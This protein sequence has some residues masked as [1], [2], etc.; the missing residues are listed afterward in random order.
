MKVNKWTLGLAAIGLVSLPTAMLAEEELSPVQTAL[1]STIISGYVNAAAQWDF[2][3]GNQNAPGYSYNQ[4]KQDG[5]S[6]NSVL[7][8][9]EK[10]YE[11]DAPG[12]WA[13]G[14]KID[15]MF[16]PDADAFGTTMNTFGFSGTTD[17]APPG[18]HTHDY[19]N[20][21]SDTDNFALRQ[22]HLN[23]RAPVGRGLDFKV[24]VFDTI[25]GYESHDAHKNP[26]YTRSYGYTIEPLSHTGVLASYEFIEDTL[27]ASAGIANTVGPAINSRAYYT[28][29]ESFKTY[30]GSLAFT[31]PESM[32]FLKGST[33]Y[34]GIVNGFAGGTD[35][36]THYYAGGTLMTPVEDLRAGVAFDYVDLHSPAG[37]TDYHWAIG[38]YLTYKATDKLSLH[39]RGEYAA[40]SGDALLGASKLVGATATVQY[41]LWRNVMSRLE[42]RW[43]HAADGDYAF[44]GGS[45]GRNPGVRRN[46]YMAA[47]N[48]IYQF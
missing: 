1:A 17:P 20:G 2:G 27:V 47:L 32:G 23:L 13:A 4:N 48:T 24:G 33:L 36:L 41:D 45:P 11:A 35:N 8:S 22:A 25:V 5:F 30:M 29:A 16:G 7:L 34:G 18:G 14:Y 9:V 12:G 21:G 38:G 43:D 19:A 31:A 40:G 37:S 26:N 39:G 28:K 10:P 6:L 42:L 3:T 44:G 46:H 15:L